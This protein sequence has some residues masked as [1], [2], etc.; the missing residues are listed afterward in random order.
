[1]RAVGILGG[2]FDPIHIGHLA[3]ADCAIAQLPIDELLLVPA[4]SPPHKQGRRISPA[5]DRVAML[6]LAVA[7]RRS[8]SVDTIELE[9]PGPSY[10]VDTVAALI[11]AAEHAGTP[12]QPT[13][14]MSADAFAELPTWHEPHLLVALARIAVAPRRGH[15][16]PDPG[17]VVAK[18]PGLQG[19]VDLFDGPDLDVS[20]SD[21]RARVA[22]G[23]PIDHLV[24]P[25]VAAY[26]EKHD[27][28]RESPGRNDRS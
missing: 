22:A 20:S 4:G 13:V 28:Y 15:V 26:I 27:L 21:I 5:G 7:G 25:P 14:I 6:R 1:V 11:D 9:R 18:L 16:L 24:P 8:I 23:R 10:T 17:P 3:L 19:R 12:M 2:T